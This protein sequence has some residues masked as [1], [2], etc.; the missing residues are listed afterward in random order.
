MKGHSLLARLGFA[1]AGLREAYA[2]ERSFRT[3]CRFALAATVALVALRPAPAWWGMF[4]LT[5]AL[6]LAL[7][8]LNSALEGFIDL[9]RPDIHPEIKII[10]DMAAGAVLLLSIAALA[11]GAAMVV[12]TGPRR[13]AEWMR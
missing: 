10:K 11:V 9:V 1:A 7:E 5:I 4:A 13:W 2:R 8:M 6:V 3:H 12:D